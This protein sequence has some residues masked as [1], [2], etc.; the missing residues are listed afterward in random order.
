VRLHWRRIIAK[1]YILEA[2]QLHHLAYTK[3]DILLTLGVREK[4]D[5]RR[6]LVWEQFFTP[7]Q[8][9]FFRELQCSI[10]GHFM[11]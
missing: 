5:Y 10:T 11:L 4:F 2:S 7:A 3:C 8:S 6:L 9:S 1:Y